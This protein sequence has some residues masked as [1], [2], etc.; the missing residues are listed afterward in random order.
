MLKPFTERETMERYLDSTA[1][2]EERVED[3]LSKMTLQEKV[4][5]LN[6]RLYGFSIYE[7]DKDGSF[8]LKEEFEQEVN[9]WSGLGVLYGLY[10]ADPWSGRTEENGITAS[11]MKDAY[12]AVQKYVLE[13]SRLGI[14]VLMSTECP[15]G[16]QS[17]D[18][19]L[20]PVNAAAGA[21]FDL[22]LLEKAYEACGKQLKSSHVDLALMSMLDVMR[23][24]RW[25]RC[26]ECYSE[27]PYLSGEMAYAA[28]KG[29]RKSGTAVVAKHFCA[30]GEGTGGVN[31]SAA[32]IG[33]RELREIHLRPAKKSVEAGTEGIMAAYNEI[34]GI[35]CHGNPK[36][37]Q[38][39]LREE[40]GF[41]GIVMADGFAVDSLNV[42]TA[43]TMRSGAMALKSGVDVSLWDKGFTLLEEAVKEGLVAEELVDASVRK[44]LTLKF[45]RGLFEHPY[46]EEDAL[47]EK[48]S[49][50]DQMSLKM[51]RESVVLLKNEKIL[52]QIMPKRILVLGPNAESYYALMGDYS[53]PRKEEDTCSVLKGLQ[54]VYPD[55]EITFAGADYEKLT[56]DFARGEKKT[57]EYDLVVLVGG[58]SSS[59]FEG[60][61]FDRNGAA[62]SSATAMECGEGMDKADLM[63]PGIDVK[64]VEK[65]LKGHV[66]VVGIAIAGRPYIVEPAAEVCDAF[67]YAFYPGPFGGRAIAEILAGKCSPTGRMPASLPSREGQLPA[68]YNY[69]NSYAGMKY[70]DQKEKPKYVFGDGLQYSE[71]AY[72]AKVEQRVTGYQ[73]LQNSQLNQPVLTCRIEAEN[74]GTYEVAAIPQV[75]LSRKNGNVTARVLELKG[76]SREML[77]PGER[78]EMQIE[79]TKEAFCFWNQE[80]Q[81]TA[82]ADLF[83]LIIKDQGQEL[84]RQEV[85]FK[86]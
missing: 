79:L 81:Y 16:H 84:F 21:T 48:E 27:D 41:D 31:A 33:E 69:K 74:T 56:I 63:L 14:P 70:C 55:A 3:L 80:M 34:D 22:A 54:E 58:G 13:H 15:H 40:F 85:Q 76:F 36:L 83:E 38:G 39:V 26:E 43:D 62:L 35:Y 25:G 1:P 4:G 19:G 86:R 61:E 60:A 18:G 57:E 10:R 11:R 50:V 45:E 52:P 32:R 42:V 71:V 2:I 51:A 37:L 75:Y 44:V 28:T 5:Q 66:P 72:R 73:T 59:R 9:R 29:M 30:Q 68:Y 17:L 49:G 78:K 65:Y 46:M 12:N 77:N 7:Y 53:P 64:F 24:P 23:D 8:H 82:G 47:T 20:L 6:Q 67:L